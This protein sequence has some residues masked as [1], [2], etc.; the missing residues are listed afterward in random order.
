MPLLQLDMIP[1]S[2]FQTF[3]AKHT[4]PTIGASGIT[5][6]P[7]DDS[8]DEDEDELHIISDEKIPPRGNLAELSSG[9]G[10]RSEIGDGYLDNQALDKMTKPVDI[11]DSLVSKPL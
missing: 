5:F 7:A 11:T 4:P 2:R 10:H 1:P 8:D 9:S 6:K 3:F